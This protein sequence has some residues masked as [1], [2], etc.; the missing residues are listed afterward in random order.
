LAAV[1]GAQPDPVRAAR[2]IGA[3]THLL[4]TTGAA[5][6]PVDHL[7]FERTRAEVRAALGEKAFARACAEGQVLSAEQ[8]V[9][10]ALDTGGASSSSLQVWPDSVRRD[11]SRHG[12]HAG[13]SKPHK[14]PLSRREI[15]V[16]RLVAEGLS[17]QQIA[18]RLVTE[19]RTIESHL[20]HI[21]KK[22]LLPRRAVVA[23]A[24]EMVQAA[25][26]D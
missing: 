25:A 19:K 10:L 16:L 17:N 6:E 24:A 21:G 13:P 2:L 11:E 9:R 12:A 20:A 4:E 7:T 26:A 23:R 15:E 22:L 5:L 14:S 18:E 3:A 8:A 1:V